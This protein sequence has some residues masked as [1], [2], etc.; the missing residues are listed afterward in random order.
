[1]AGAS[2]PALA[3]A[4]SQAGGLGSIATGTSSVASMAGRLIAALLVATVATGCASG[5]PWINS[6]LPSA[7]LSI[8]LSDP[9]LPIY[10]AD[11]ASMLVGV[12]LS[13][14]G[15]RA[16]AFGYGVLQELKAT[17]F[18]WNG[19][20]TTML[21]RVSLIGGVSGGSITAAYYAAFGDEIFT[22]FESDY[23]LHDFQNSLI[24]QTLNPRNL[25]A[26][27][28]PWYGRG[29]VLADRFDKLFRG[30]TFADLA[31]RRKSLR[32]LITATELTTGSP[33]EFT[34]QQ[35]ALICSDL[36]SVPLSFAVAASSS[37]PV[38][39]SPLTLKNHANRCAAPDMTSQLLRASGDTPY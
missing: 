31:E 38:L 3:A 16:A 18:N 35:F 34:P 30:V 2:T 17:R 27:T 28:S 32:L 37:V 11:A 4:V 12:T 26:M 36:T 10:D 22:R 7:Q 29:N 24:G 1:M 8:G 20:T 21:D 13:G 23:L 39:F 9:G 25:H 14:G 5:R 15:A 33:F 19:Q 6:A